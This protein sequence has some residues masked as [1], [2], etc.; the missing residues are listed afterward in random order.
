MEVPGEPKDKTLERFPE[1]RGP[2]LM[3]EAGNPA[4]RKN[5]FPKSRDLRS[6]PHALD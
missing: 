1:G 3:F 4:L 5:W 2:A 6:D